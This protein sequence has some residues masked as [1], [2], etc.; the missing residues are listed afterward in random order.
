MTES[1]TGARMSDSL[2]ITS[3]GFTHSVDNCLPAAAVGAALRLV[4][5]I[6]DHGPDDV[7]AILDGLTRQDL[8][9]LVVT[10]AAMVPDDYSPVELLAWN[11]SRYAR[12]TTPPAALQPP[13]FPAIAV[14]RQLKPH[15]THAAFTLHRVH[16]EEPCDACW[17]GERDYQ[18]NRKR[19]NRADTVKEATG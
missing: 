17:H 15:G 19:N 18:R 8:L 7:A 5:A 6:H 14:T 2:V 12:V 1:T 16:R 9:A 13:L 11:D 3:T 10:V 4:G